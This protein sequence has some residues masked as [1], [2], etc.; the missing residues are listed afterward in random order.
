LVGASVSFTGTFRIPVGP[1]ETSGLCPGACFVVDDGLV[2]LQ[3]AERSIGFA[4]VRLEIQFGAIEHKRDDDD[5]DRGR[6]DN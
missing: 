5:R 2:P 4:L 3:D 6:E 1:H